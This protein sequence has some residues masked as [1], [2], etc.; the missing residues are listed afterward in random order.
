MQLQPCS[1]CHCT[2]PPPGPVQSIVTAQP[3]L[4]GPAPHLAATPSTLRPNTPPPPAARPS[5][6]TL[7]CCLKLSRLRR[8]S[9]LRSCCSTRVSRACRHR[10]RHGRLLTP[11]TRLQPGDRA[12][13]GLPSACCSLPW[14]A[15]AWHC[16]G[17]RPAPMP[18]QQACCP[19]PT[20]SFSRAACPLTFFSA[21][22]S[23]SRSSG[24]LSSYRK[25]YLP[26]EDVWGVGQGSGGAGDE[27]DGRWM[28]LHKGSGREVT[29]RC[30]LTRRM[31]P[32]LSSP[33]L[34]LGLV[35]LASA[36]RLKARVAH[37]PAAPRRREGGRC[38]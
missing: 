22:R 1:P 17:A 20:C 11:R 19:P 6:R 2:G 8:A 7:T 37:F 4:S 29:A 28:L 23:S 25:A 10:G 3:A 15:K 36:E 21:A 32:L 18:G 12:P 5:S 26:E 27:G 30:T 14:L 38:T 31:S 9:S 34:E 33:L 16:N 13:A 35:V 24:I